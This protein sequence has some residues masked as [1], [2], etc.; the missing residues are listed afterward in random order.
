MKI[1]HLLLL[2]IIALFFSCSDSTSPNNDEN[3]FGIYLLKD[4]LLITSDAKIIPLDILQVQD[5]PIINI[6][7]IEEYEWTE[8]VIT[9]TPEAF[10]KFGGVQQGK[11]KSTL[12]LPFIVM[13][14]GEKIYLGNIYPMQS[15]YIHTDLPF[16]SVSPFTEM[17]IARAPDNN[18]EDKRINEIIYSVLKRNNKLEL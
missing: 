11:I 5:S 3:V 18:I 17:R 8:Q 4:T 16:I 7:D 9:L 10:I 2:F 12:G 15:S 1:Q 13:V 6:N 14:D